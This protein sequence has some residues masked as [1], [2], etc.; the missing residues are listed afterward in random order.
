[1]P[2]LK[3]DPTPNPVPPDRAGDTVRRGKK[4]VNW[5]DDPEILQRLTIVATL[6][7]KNKRGY[8]I[9]AETKVSLE[10]A[11]R[12]IS[13]VRELWAEDARE[14][15]KT[16][17]DIALAQYSQVIHDAREDLVKVKSRG[18][19]V[20]AAYYNVI[21]RAQ[22]SIDSVSGIAEKY[23]HSGPNGGPIPVAVTNMESIRKKRWNQVAD[24]LGDLAAKEPDGTTEPTP[25][26][27][28]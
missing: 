1:M 20:R 15:I 8:E 27:K 18:N 2:K 17:K 4:S 21:L 28:P 6:M 12:D 10:T 25:A 23:E 13:R 3:V 26:K 14:H 5:K 7:N 9:A 11:R 22:K 24:S 19:P 16:A